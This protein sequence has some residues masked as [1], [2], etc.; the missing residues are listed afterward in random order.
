MP[1]LKITV[2][3]AGAFGVSAAIELCRRSH[4]VT[5]V[6]PGAL[7]HPLASSTDISK[8]VRMDY[9][10]DDLYTH[11]AAEALVRWDEW[12]AT[13]PW[14]P[15]RETG[16]LLLSR[17]ELLPGSFEGDSFEL[18]GRRGVAV[19]RVDQRTI[20]SRFP[21]WRD[22]RYVDG[23]F[24][25]RAGWSPS[26]RVVGH[27]VE[28]AR[29]LGVVVRE[30]EGAVEFVEQDDRVAGIVTSQGERIASDVVVVAAGAWTQTIVPE[31][32]V[33]VAAVGQPVF[34]LRPSNPEAFSPPSFPC[35]T[36]DI[37]R[38]GWYGFPAN[39]DG[40][41]KIANHGPGRRLHPDEPRE[42]AEAE[43]ARLRSFLAGSLPSLVDAPL[44]A[45]R[46]CLYCD[47]WDGN[48]CIDHVPG[49]P[50]L[51]VAAGDSGHGFKFAPVI[52]DVVADVVEER[53]NPYAARFAWRAAGARTGEDA[54][55]LGELAE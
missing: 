4:R 51:V 53:S 26:G 7:P 36:A 21:A 37:S 39:D 31:L 32:A 55:F 54:R 16:L 12:N 50:G 19:E 45:T 29:A 14:Q 40:I 11:L 34:H 3:G 5:L 47:S 9:G 15:Y 10:G 18:V 22:G 13:W 35:W 33:G 2:V 27:L 49:R 25:P 28:R 46:L 43:I 42:V 17:T 48:F 41:L 6:D 20:A 23:Y 52:G 44:V 8:F 24:N 30:G 38:T 1:G